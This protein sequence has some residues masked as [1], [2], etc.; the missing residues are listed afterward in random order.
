MFFK[1]VDIPGGVAGSSDSI[2]S[3]VVG[4]NARFVPIPNA[5]DEQKNDTNDASATRSMPFVPFSIRGRRPSKSFTTKLT[6]IFESP[7]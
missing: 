6:T 3:N 1:N 4:D 2:G 5:V 7:E